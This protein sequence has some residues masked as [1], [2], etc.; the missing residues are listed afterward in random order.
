M[1]FVTSGAKNSKRYSSYLCQRSHNDGAWACP[2]ARAP[3]RVI[4]G[5]VVEQ[6][7]ASEGAFLASAWK[8]G[9]EQANLGRKDKRGSPTPAGLA[10]LEVA[11][12]AVRRAAWI[13]LDPK[14][15][16]GVLQAAVS[17]VTFDP[18]TGEV[19]IHR[20]GDDLEA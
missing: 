9:V 17:K 4:E 6:L 14:E 20:I 1:T 3:M 18:E 2:Q 16:V 15:R 8:Q 13:A 5:P 10:E 19:L 7:L 11:P 12:P